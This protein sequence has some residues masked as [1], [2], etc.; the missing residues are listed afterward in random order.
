MWCCAGSPG[1]AVPAPVT[2][3]VLFC[4]VYRLCLLPLLTVRVSHNSVP[5]CVPSVHCLPVAS[6]TSQRVIHFPLAHHPSLRFSRSPLLLCCSRHRPVHH[7]CVLRDVDC[8]DDR[9]RS[10][11]LRGLQGG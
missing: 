10:H 11:L 1:I 7:P 2:S 4:V 9:G 6:V 8:A 3:L 5:F